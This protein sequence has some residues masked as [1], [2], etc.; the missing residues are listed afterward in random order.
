[1]LRLKNTVN[2]SGTPKSD[3][4]GFQQ[5]QYCSL[6]PISEKRISAPMAYAP[7]TTSL[8]REKDSISNFSANSSLFSRLLQKYYI[9]EE[10]Y[11][12]VTN[13]LVI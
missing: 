8:I 9:C 12:S 5:Y 13:N 2:E 11:R 1:M 10:Y 4:N 7:T 6:R 3:E